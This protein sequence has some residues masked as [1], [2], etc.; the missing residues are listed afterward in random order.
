[1]RRRPHQNARGVKDPGRTKVAKLDC[2]EARGGADDLRKICGES[3]G[4]RFLQREKRVCCVCQRKTMCQSGREVHVEYF[5][6]SLSPRIASYF[7]GGLLL[8]ETWILSSVAW[9]NARKESCFRGFEV[10]T[11]TVQLYKVLWT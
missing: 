9:G 7:I 1:M 10:H 6:V 11:S 2:T 8:I 3:D 5:D 4:D